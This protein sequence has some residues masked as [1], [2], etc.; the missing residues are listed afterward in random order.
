[1]FAVLWGLV[2]FAEVPDA[3]TLL[4]ALVIAGAGIYVWHRETRKG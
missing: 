4:G 2:L 3:M 1:V